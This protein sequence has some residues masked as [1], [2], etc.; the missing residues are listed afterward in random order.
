MSVGRFG[1]DGTG[2]AAVVL[3][4]FTGSPYD[5]QPLAESLAAGGFAVELPLL[6]GHGDGIRGVMAATRAEWRSD[7]DAAI[8]RACARANAETVGVVGLSMGALLAL[9]AAHRVPSVGRVASLAAP[10]SLSVPARA[11]AKLAA[12]SD[13]RWLRELV[14]P[15]FGGNDIST[16]ER[17]PGP[18]GIPFAALHQLSKLIDEVRA[19]LPTVTCPL[20]LLH[21]HQDHTAT[22]ESALVIASN[23]GASEVELEIVERGYHVIT[24]DVDAADVA[25]RVTTF[26]L[27]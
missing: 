12:T 21:A 6:R 19:Q 5:V 8:E 16:R 13:R 11:L 24:R 1:R 27:G 25:R 20:L 3:H 2:R 26:L 23:A 9:D 22:P 17:L 4:G 7:V 10:L 14:W 15:K 18:R